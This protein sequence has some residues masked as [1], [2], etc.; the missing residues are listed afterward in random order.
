MPFVE[1]PC[2]LCISKT[3]SSEEGDY[4]S[5]TLNDE[6]S[7]CRLADIKMSMEAFAYALSSVHTSG[8]VRF[9]ADAPIEQCQRHY[10]HPA[11]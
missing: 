1:V 2:S 3:H 5:I 6:I 4:M 7:G 8:T 11:A 9:N 10:V